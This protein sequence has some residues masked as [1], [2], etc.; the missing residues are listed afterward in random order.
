MTI[1]PSALGVIFSL[2]ALSLSAKPPADIQQRLD[3]YVKDKPS[4]IAV[5]W[6]DKDGP[7]FFSAGKFA[8]NESRPITP[9]TEFEIGSVTKVFTALLLVESERAGKVSRDEPVAKYLLPDGDPDL[10]ALRRITFLSLSTHTSGLPRMPS[11]WTGNNAATPDDLVQGLRKDGPGAPVSRGFAYSNFGVA[12]MGNALGRAWGQPYR[13]ALRKHVLEPLGM[14]ATYIPAPGDQPPA[15]LAAGHAN[16]SPEAA[17]TLDGFAPAGGIR[18]TARDMAI[19]L[20]AALD[21]DTGPLAAAF[22]ESTKPLMPIPE[23]EGQIGLNWMIMGDP[24]KPILWHNGQTSGYHCFVGIDRANGRG[25]AVLVNETSGMEPL[26]FALLGAKPP[27]TAP[28]KIENSR[29]YVGRYPLN[30]AFSITVR[31]ESGVLTAQGSGQ[32]RIAMRQVAPDRFA[33]VGVPAELSFERDADNAV[34]ALVLHQNGRDQRGQRGPVPPDPKETSLPAE[35]LREYAGRY[36]LSPNMTITFTEDKGHLQAQLTGQPKIAVFA[37]A[38]DEFFYKVVDARLSFS[39]GADGKV[40]GV[41]LHQG[42]STLTGT[43]Q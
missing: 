5:A 38:K 16:G 20:R 31:N 27:R 36:V 42:A 15:L 22:R 30:P 24:A 10:A 2:G 21:Q 9:D 37:S 12:L 23:M 19:F 14:K 18:S 13:D 40:A 4:G 7:A 32:S 35:I 33:L 43:K 28:T 1:K 41:I 29:D 3:A 39:R 8:A 34:V 6:V 17:I 11:G 26:A 25:V